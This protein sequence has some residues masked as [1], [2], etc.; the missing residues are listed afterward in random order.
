[1]NST[2]SNGVL[3]STLWY[4][5]NY[6]IGSSHP[7]HDLLPNHASITR[8]VVV[9]MMTMIAVIKETKIHFTK[10]QY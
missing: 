6:E 5:D 1:M 10:Y 9:V 3:L 4:P 7:Q 8:V 2:A